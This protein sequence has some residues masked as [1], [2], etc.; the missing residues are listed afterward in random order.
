VTEQTFKKKLL[1]PYLLAHGCIVVTTNS[2][3]TKHRA[4]QHQP[5]VADLIVMNRRQKYF[6]IEAKTD[7]G[8]AQGSQVKR[9]L[10]LNTLGHGRIYLFVRPNDYIQ[11]LKEVVG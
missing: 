6:E 5:G 9:Q 3:R 10:M 4:T 1:I 7:K 11:E 2:R 8:I